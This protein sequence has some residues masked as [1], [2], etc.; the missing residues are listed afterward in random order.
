MSA[1]MRCAE[2]TN[3]TETFFS[4]PPKPKRSTKHTSLCPPFP[5]SPLLPNRSP[6]R[7]VEVVAVGVKVVV[8]VRVVAIEDDHCTRR[9]VP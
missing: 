8:V 4:A 2:H 9:A 3:D 1:S 7:D 5:F 6:K